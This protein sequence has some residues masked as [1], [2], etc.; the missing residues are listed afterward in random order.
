MEVKVLKNEKDYMEVEI[1]NL[2]IA[3]LLRN[4]LWKNSAVEA[5]AWRREHPSKNPVLII[6]VKEGTARRALID[7]IERVQKINGKILE[8]FKKAVK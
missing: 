7:C 3:E 2:T 1:D 4:Q 6:K 5:A 8:E